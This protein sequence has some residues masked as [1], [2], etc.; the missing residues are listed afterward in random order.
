MRFRRGY[1]D[2]ASTSFST[3]REKIGLDAGIEEPDF[4]LTIGD[5]TVLPAELV[6]PWPG[7]DTVTS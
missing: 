5:R 6:E 4:E 3:E 2:T 7:H 1:S